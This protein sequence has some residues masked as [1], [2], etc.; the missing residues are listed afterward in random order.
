MEQLHEKRG[1]GYSSRFSI[2]DEDLPPGWRRVNPGGSSK[3]TVWYDPRGK[4]Y[5]SST[6]VLHAIRPAESTSRAI[7]EGSEVESELD[8]ETGGETSEFEPSPT[9]RRL[10]E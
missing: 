9:K 3:Y 5:K 10:H 6:D 1:V 8:T 2:R 4:R 7:A